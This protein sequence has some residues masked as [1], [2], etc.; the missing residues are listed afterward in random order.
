MTH[1][2]VVQAVR[3]AGCTLD[4][5]QLRG[6]TR[7]IELLARDRQRFDLTGIRRDDELVRRMVG[8]SLKLLRIIERDGLPAGTELADVGSG[9]GV[10]GI[11]IA[12]ARPDVRVALIES[13]TSKAGWLETAVAELGL[14]IV[15]VPSPA[16]VAG[17]QPQHR[18]HYEVV[19]ARAVATLPA[20]LELT[21]PLLRVGGR[22]YAA[23]GSRL[24]QEIELA[25]PA[26]DQL[27]A[28]I[29]SKH[30]IGDDPNAPVVLV[31][32]K[33]KPTAQRFPRS[34]AALRKR[35]LSAKREKA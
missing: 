34:S 15:V 14:Q 2:L 17:R 13:R 33:V 31:V 18:Q 30:P 21:M 24:D 25:S 3:D 9:G 23:K 8:E 32:R 10:P 20:L 5:G 12:I 4:E 26:L 28:E 1:D 29:M 16:E 6:L 7:Y 22:V 27:S 35:P 19:V 11:P